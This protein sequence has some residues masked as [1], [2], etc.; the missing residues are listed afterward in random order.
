MHIIYRGVF[1]LTFTLVLTN[2]LRNSLQVFSLEQVCF[3]EISGKREDEHFL[4]ILCRIKAMNYS[5]LVTYILSRK[6]ITQH[7][8]VIFFNLSSSF[9]S[10]NKKR[11][12]NVS[13][14]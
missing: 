9:F 6:E 11:K 3:S 8:F 5:I 13:T 12:T 2:F 10:E 4:K 7:S 14:Y 1:F